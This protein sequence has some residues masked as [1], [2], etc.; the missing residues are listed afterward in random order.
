MK[1]IIFFSLLGLMGLAS[2]TKNSAVSPSQN[3]VTPAAEN[4]LRV[5]FPNATSITWA[6]VSP[7]DLQASFKNQNKQLLA[8]VTKAG[9]LMYTANS[10]TNATLPAIALDYLATNF[11]G[12]K[13]NRAGEKKD[14]NG[15]TL[16][17]VAD[18]TFNSVDYDVHFDA[19]GKFLSSNEESGKHNGQGVKLSQAEL[20]TAIKT[21]LDTNYPSYKFDDA[22]SF[23]ING[24]VKGYG[25]RITTADG[26][27]VGLIFDAAG[28]FL[29]SREGDLGHHDGMGPG[30]GGPGGPDGK[31]DG[32]GRGHDGVSIVKID[33]TALP[34]AAIMYLDAHYAGYT[35]D[36][37]GSIS[38]NGVL[39]QYVVDITLSTKHYDVIFD[40]A[41]VFVKEI[42][43]K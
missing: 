2:C 27:E 14:K 23:S 4:A 1:K 9:K 16:G 29:R 26:K 40:T 30:H 43:H 13:L 37:A 20:P 42:T 3:A 19:T 25:V 41:G 32:P 11:A 28:V 15:A 22:I 17:Y 6:T 24:T 5:A 18:I 21:Y 10:I 8:G 35:F 36:R 34:A 31:P 12:Y 33:K 39:S 7:T 38:L